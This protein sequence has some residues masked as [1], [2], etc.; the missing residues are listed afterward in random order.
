MVG[1]C[2]KKTPKH[3]YVIVKCTYLRRFE[4]DIDDV[5]V[6]LWKLEAF[7]EGPFIQGVPLFVV[8]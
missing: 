7:D 5:D 1:R 4:L 2:F 8:V 3:P 6:G